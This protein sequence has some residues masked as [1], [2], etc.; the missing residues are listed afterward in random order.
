M[1]KFVWKDNIIVD[2][3]DGVTFEIPGDDDSI[4]KQMEDVNN[5]LLKRIEG[6]QDNYAAVMNAVLDAIDELLGD[7][8]TER[9]FK[10]HA[11]NARN[12][13]NAYL[14]TV[15][16]ILSQSFE[17]DDQANSLI[18]DLGKLGKNSSSLP[19]VSEDAKRAAFDKAAAL[20]VN[21]GSVPTA[22]PRL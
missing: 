11:L 3:G 4:K 17:Y 5:R 6:N 15:E 21:I 14:F 18:N 22:K 16:K 2:F 12:V 20:G 7:D 19:V 13:L 1:G 10:G 9:L 8:A